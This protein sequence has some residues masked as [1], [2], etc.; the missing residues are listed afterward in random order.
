MTDLTTTIHRKVK[1]R[2]KEIFLFV[3]VVA[4]VVCVE[5]FF[6]SCLGVVEEV[7]SELLRLGLNK[8]CAKLRIQSQED[9][10]EFESRNRNQDFESDFQNCEM[11]IEKS[12][13]NYH[14]EEKQYPMAFSILAHRDLVHLTK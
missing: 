3:L 1:K 14:E 2:K 12:K 8:T 4:I 7:N 10:D 13:V 11:F 5:I 6:N 9:C